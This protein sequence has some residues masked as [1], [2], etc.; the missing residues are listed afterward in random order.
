MT[1]RSS[2]V[3]CKLDVE[4]IV[5]A[6]LQYFF[7][8]LNYISTSYLLIKSDTFKKMLVLLGILFQ[9]NGLLTMSSTVAG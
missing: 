3:S 8:D 2:V 7:V 5:S 4:S 1:K 9:A 6:I